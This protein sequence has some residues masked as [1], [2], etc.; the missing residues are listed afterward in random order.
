MSGGKSLLAQVVARSPAKWS[1]TLADRTLHLPASTS[2]ILASR[3]AASFRLS[4]GH[5]SSW[6]SRRGHL[7]GTGIAS[8]AGRGR[9]WALPRIMSCGAVAVLLEN[10]RRGSWN[11][12]SAFIRRHGLPGDWVSLASKQQAK[13]AAEE[14]AALRLGDLSAEERERIVSESDFLAPYRSVVLLVGLVASIGALRDFVFFMLRQI[15]PNRGTQ[16]LDTN[17]T[18]DLDSLAL[19]LFLAGVG[20]GMLYAAQVLMAPSPLPTIEELIQDM[21]TE[22]ASN[23]RV[24]T[25]QFTW[26]LPLNGKWFYG[27]GNR[28]CYT[29]SKGADGTWRYSEKLNGA[30][31]SSILLPQKQWL[32]GKLTD[33]NGVAV[34]WIRVRR[35]SDGT[36]VS[37]VCML[38]ASHWANKNVAYSDVEDDAQPRND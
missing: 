23:E 38:G 22:E 26:G 33:S 34:G 20:I 9:S 7:Y 1:A 13:V 2:L 25:G 30:S 4:P 28:Q 37:N 15:F 35:R 12:G 14:R 18:S 36:A 32:Q 24:K 16:V 8:V 5:T 11:R 29:I 3:T 21:D 6:H 19:S 10:R 31:Y 27:E 17:A